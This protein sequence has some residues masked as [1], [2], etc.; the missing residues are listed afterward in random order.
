MSFEPYSSGIAVKRSIE[1]FK[2]NQYFV[3]TMFL[4]IFICACLVIHP[5]QTIFLYLLL[6][7]SYQTVP[8]SIFQVLLLHKRIQQ[9]VLQN[10]LAHQ[11]ISILQNCIFDFFF[12][13]SEIGIFFLPIKRVQIFL[14]NDL[15]EGENGE[16]GMK[17]LSA[18]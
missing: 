17:N 4:K 9:I 8:N 14:S 15:C 7:L 11:N 18:I 10:N 16:K 2:K 12:Y 5:L 13:S 3:T 1:I 6:I